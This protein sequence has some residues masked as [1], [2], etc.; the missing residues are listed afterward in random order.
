MALTRIKLRNILSYGPS[1]QELD[2]EPLNVLIGPNASGK[3][4]LIE[5]L[6]LLKRHRTDF[7]R[8]LSESGGP[9]EWLWQEPVGSSEDSGTAEIEL[10]A[11]LTGVEPSLRYRLSFGARGIEDEELEAQALEVTLPVTPLL[12]RSSHEASLFLPENGVLGGPRKE[13]A[14][15]VG[16]HE[17]VATHFRDPLSFP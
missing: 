10:A 8:V 3:S 11:N 14:I 9:D 12:T 6:G 17:P 5:V 4:N 7:W 2:L 15:G 16:I 1:A 13:R